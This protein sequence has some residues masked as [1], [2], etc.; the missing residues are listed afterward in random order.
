M[1][2]YVDLHCIRN[3]KQ[4]NDYLKYANTV[5]FCIRDLNITVLSNHHPG[6]L[7]LIPSTDTEGL[8]YLSYCAS[9]S[10]HNI[11]FI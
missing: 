7:E 8:L 2:T 9:L 4:S 10:S 6:F 5:P 3:N 11:M 1:I